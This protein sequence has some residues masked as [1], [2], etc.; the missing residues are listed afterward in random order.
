MVIGVV[1]QL[2]RF[3]S[4]PNGQTFHGVF[5]W[6][7]HPITTYPIHLLNGP[8]LQHTAIPWRQGSGKGGVG[9]SQLSAIYGNLS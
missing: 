9:V 3:T 5:K 8:I 2:E 6:G 1:P 4:F 7:A